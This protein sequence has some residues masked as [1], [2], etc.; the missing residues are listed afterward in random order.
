M[1]RRELMKIIAVATGVA[2][3]GADA[4]AYIEPEAA[5]SL[6]ESAFSKDDFTLLEAVAETI[7]PRTDTP[8]A[9]DAGIAA[10]MVGMV[11]D[12]YDS[13]QQ[14]IFMKGLQQIDS[15]SRER[16]GNNFVALKTDQ[17]LDLLN[18][19]DTQAK[20]QNERQ[21]KQLMAAVAGEKPEPAHYFTLIKQ[22]TLFSFFS[23]KA[24]ATQVLRHVSV[25]GKYDGD[26]PYKK[27]DRA[28]APIA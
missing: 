16:F 13:A 12:C 25:P 28:W 18:E 4:L 14:A 20:A 11:T 3:V 23:S 10:F 27:G 8:G 15:R 6:Q 5:T 26:F 22:L 7:M 1:N 9:K 21:M 2:M 19:I 17:Q 24:G